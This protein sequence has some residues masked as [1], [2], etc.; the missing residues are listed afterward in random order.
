MKWIS[1][2]SQSISVD[3]SV[4]VHVGVT[5]YLVKIGSSD[6][7]TLFLKSIFLILLL[8]SFHHNGFITRMTTS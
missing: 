8:K 3:H 4:G 2:W 5:M 6:R 1:L 7:A